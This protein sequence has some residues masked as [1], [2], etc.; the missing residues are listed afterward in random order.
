M[1]ERGPAVVDGRV[2]GDRLHAR[3]VAITV[4]VVV[5]AAVA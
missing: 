1:V 3:C 4:A 2:D 5:A